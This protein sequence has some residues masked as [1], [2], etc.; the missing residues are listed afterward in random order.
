MGGGNDRV[1]VGQADVMVDL[2]KDRI[3]VRTP[4]SQTS[5]RL[6]IE[7]VIVRRA[8]ALTLIGDEKDNK[9]LAL[10]GCASAISG[11]GGDDL[12]IV[13]T[14]DCLGRVSTLAGDAGDDMLR[15]RDGRDRIIGGP[16]ADRADGRGGRDLCVAEIRRHCELR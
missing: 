5:G 9:L 4:D 2:A 16:G 10:Y 15:G 14:K 13:G 12:L 3:R 8:R 7:N 6:S 11:G 1:K